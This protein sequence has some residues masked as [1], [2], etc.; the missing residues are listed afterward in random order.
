MPGAYDIELDGVG[1]MLVAGS[2][3]R[4]QEPLAEGRL[5]RVRLLDFYGGAGRAVQQER[6]RFWASVGAMPALDSQ[7]VSAG[8]KR[9]DVTVSPAQAFV[10]TKRSWAFA[11]P[12]AVYLVNGRNIY[13]VATS[14]GSFSGLT[15][16]VQMAADAV[17]AAL[18]GTLLYVC[19]A[20]AATVGALN[21][22]NNT[23]TANALTSEYGTLLGNSAGRLVVTVNGDT[24]LLRQWSSSSSYSEMRIDYPARRMVSHDGSLWVVTSGSLWRLDQGG[25]AG[26]KVEASLPLSAYSDDGVWAASLQDGLYVW[27]GKRVR[28]FR[29]VDSVGVLEPWGPEGQTSNGACVAGGYL[30]CEVRNAYTGAS[31]VWANDGRGW[32]QI[33]SST[34]PV[35]QW[36]VNVAGP[37]DDA[38]VL[39]G[40]GSTNNTVS[41]WQLVRKAGSTGLRD[42]WSVTTSLLDGGERD[43]PKLWRALGCELAWPDERA[44]SGVVY[45]K[46]EYSVDG[47]Q[48]WVQAGS[49]FG[50]DPALYGRRGSMAVTLTPPV[51]ERYL[52]VRVSMRNITAWC[53]VLVGVWAEHELVQ[54]GATRKK[55]RFVVQCR[56]GQVLRNGSVHPL[57]GW[58]QAREL[59]EAFASE[60]AVTF[61][62]IDYD[63]TG[64]VERV[65]VVGVRE[66][67]TKGEP[68][69]GVGGREVEVTLVA[70]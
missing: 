2:Y 26:G 59:W 16:V 27:L 6:D 23:W 22:T 42:S 45:V 65:R 12:S 52:Q 11:T 34:S 55:W 40:R 63:L 62:D 50:F 58:Q 3:Q 53:P 46:L 29:K 19:F 64:V 32:W 69:D 17:D 5:E 28:R 54:A 51:K 48:T 20:G 44:T 7:G 47:G 15:H 4:T 56:D 18:V 49:E 37:A 38:D 24:T 10:P 57:S 43:R 39:A 25:P 21:V 67:L 41:V 30:V 66:T 14:G 1:F 31:E 13:T 68:R 36:P 70:V 8:P 9:R 60:A 35:W 61:K 33:E